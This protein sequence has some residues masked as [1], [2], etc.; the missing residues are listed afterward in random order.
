M[1][2]L[3]YGTLIINFTY[4]GNHFTFIGEKHTGNK[5]PIN[6]NGKALLETHI[7]IN[8][9][10]IKTIKNHYQQK[11]NLNQSYIDLYIY[12]KVKNTWKKTLKDLNVYP[13]DTRIPADYPKS[14]IRYIHKT[15]PELIN[16]LLFDAKRVEALISN[17]QVSKF[18]KY[19]N[20]RIQQY[21]RDLQDK[22]SSKLLQTEGEIILDYEII[23][24][25]IENK[26][27]NVIGIF[28]KNHITNLKN[29]LN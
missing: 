15:N 22:K 29:I 23:K 5:E 20:Q 1:N 2:N 18:R 7:N 8:K 6:F 27:K 16:K 26:D 19:L 4:N 25:V 3:Q 12:N 11:P 17:I 21:I 9:H 28:G 10:S 13:I 14:Q 24:A